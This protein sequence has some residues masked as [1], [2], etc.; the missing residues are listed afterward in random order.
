MNSHED[1][2]TQISRDNVRIG[3]LGCSEIARRKFIPAL[4]GC[5][6][7]R[8]AAVSSRDREKAAALLPGID[9]PV[10][11]HEELLQ[12]SSVDLV[13][14]SLPNHLHEEWSIRALDAGK[15]LIC[16]KPLSTSLASAER[17]LN[18]AV[19]ND[20]LI[21]ENQMFLFHPQHAVVKSLIEAGRI[22]RVTAL[23]AF[24]G[25]PLPRKGDFRLDP[26]QGGG[27]FHDLARYPLGI[28]VHLL[29]GGLRNFRGQSLW[30]D[31][32]NTAVSGT[33][34]TDADE[35]FN[36]TIAFGQQYESL[37][38]VMG[39]AG[40]IRLER[41]FTTPDDYSNRI[42]LTEGSTV[43][44]IPVPP[45]DHF[46]LM[47]EGISDIILTGKDFSFLNRRAALIA[48]LADD[49]ERG[50]ILHEC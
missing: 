27:A 11:T 20:R 30:Q 4:E 42:I 50:C 15:H 43:T 6:N 39:D 44:E 40:K 17:I 22:G 28:A 38:E 33:A 18:C 31:G 10:L 49:M 36:F 1:S 46:Q 35:L 34:S 26:D 16:E 2:E 9:C 37:Y 29:K 32:L 23:R 3:I 48:R 14:L 5:G 12:D 41:A 8:L 21:Y 45:A 7:A 19:R 13:Y 47:I 24:F 25:F